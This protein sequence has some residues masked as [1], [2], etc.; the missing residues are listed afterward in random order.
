MSSPRHAYLSTG[1]YGDKLRSG[2]SD[3]RQNLDD[4]R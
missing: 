3:V 1:S 2:L 4:D